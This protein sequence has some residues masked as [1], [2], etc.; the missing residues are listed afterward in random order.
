MR[1]LSDPDDE[2]N[3]E[4][5]FVPGSALGE[6]SKCRARELGNLG[7]A[8]TRIYKRKNFLFLGGKKLLAH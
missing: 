8:T 1:M 6:T 4:T 5:R 2:P 7:N 3:G